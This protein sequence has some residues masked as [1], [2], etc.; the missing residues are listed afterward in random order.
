VCAGMDDGKTYAYLPSTTVQSLCAASFWTP[1]PSTQNALPTLFLGWAEAKGGEIPFFILW[2]TNHKYPKPKTHPIGLYGMKTHSKATLLPAVL[3]PRQLLPR[4]P[5]P[6]QSLAL[7]TNQGNSLKARSRATALTLVAVASAT[8][9][10]FPG[11]TA[12]PSLGVAN[13]HKEHLP[14]AT[15]L[16]R[17]SVVITT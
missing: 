13:N 15:A 6:K 5:A 7:V 4:A 11:A 1:Q 3:L 9:L 14:K 2:A 17:L 12:L 10:S 16:H 8:D